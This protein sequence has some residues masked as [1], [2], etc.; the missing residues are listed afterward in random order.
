MYDKKPMVITIDGPTAS[1]KSSLAHLIA[2]KLGL[3]HLN[4]GLLFRGLAYILLT[5]YDYSLEQLQHPLASD[6]DTVFDRHELE[7]IVKNNKVMLIYKQC[8]LTPFLKSQSMDQAASLVSMDVCVREK[9]LTFQ[10]SYAQRHAIVVDGRDAG[11]VVFPYAD[12]KIFLTAAPE[13]RA[14]RWRGGNLQKGKKYTIEQALHEVMTRDQ[15]DATRLVAPL[16]IP[17]DATVID[18]SAMDMQQ[19]F[20]QFMHI[21]SSQQ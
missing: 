4:S 7:Y 11:S 3:S 13:V 12:L 15:R 19:T 9:I 8:D 10:R 18:N 1:G 17:H 2:Q 21:F 5:Y 20:E 6:I 14:E 16:V